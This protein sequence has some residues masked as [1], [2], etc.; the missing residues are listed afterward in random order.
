[1]LNRNG[2]AG[3]EEIRKPNA[4]VRSLT[5]ASASTRSASARAADDARLLL[6]DFRNGEAVRDHPEIAP[7]L[8]E[9]WRIKSAVPRLV[10]AKGTRLLVVLA[11]PRAR[12]GR[13]LA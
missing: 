2:P 4:P 5:G 9:G 6:V 8:D 11:P 3:L 10:E 7:L 12:V 1:M 13:N